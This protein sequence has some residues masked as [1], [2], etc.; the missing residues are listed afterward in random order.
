[1]RAIL[2]MPPESPS[3]SVL[4]PETPEELRRCL[5]DGLGR[6]CPVPPHQ[7]FEQVAAKQLGLEPLGQRQ[8]IVVAVC[9]HLVLDDDDQLAVELRLD[10]HFDLAV[11]EQDEHVEATMAKAFEEAQVDDLESARDHYS[12]AEGL[13]EHEQSPRHALVLVSLSELELQRGRQREATALIDRALAI[14][15]TH[16]AALRARAQLAEQAGE[17]AISAAMHHRLLA[18]LDSAT[19][20]SRT[21]DKIA[22]ESLVAAR[23]AISSALE[24]QPNDRGLLER[25]QAVYEAQG[26]WGEAVGVGVKIAE[27]LTDPQE[28]ARAFVAAA[29]IASG[30][31]NNPRLAVALYEAAIEDDARVAGAFEAVEA[32]LVRTGDF[33]GVAKAYKRQLERLEGPSEAGARADLLRKLARVRRE[34]LQDP[35]AAIEALDRLALEQPADVEARVELAELLRQTNQPAL[36]TRVLEAAA[37]IEPARSQTYR[38]LL[39]LFDNLD[40]VDRAYN[41]SAVLVALGEADINEQLRYAQY[42]PERL[43]PIGHVLD[44]DIWD[45]LLPPDHPDAVHDLLVAIEPAALE[46]WFA[47]HEAQVRAAAPPEK[48]RQDP[49]KTTVGAVKTFHWASRVMC[50]PEP[51]IYAMPDQSRLTVATLPVKSSAVVLGRQALSGRSLAELSFMAAH[52]LAFFRPGSRLLPY[53]SDVGQV[54]SLVQAAASLCRPEMVS[55][56]DETAS[57]LRPRL[58]A[59]LA[60]EAREAVRAAVERLLDDGGKLDV[61]QWVR[62]VEIVA[63]RAALLVAG[64]VTVAGNVLAVAG[65]AP[66]GRSARDRARELLPYSISQSYT[67]LRHLLGVAV[68]QR[69]ASERPSGI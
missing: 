67:A 23:Q 27:G 60:P 69:R 4:V 41:A 64:D 52:H 18:H 58:E 28:R 49:A 21:L 47:I 68:G 43:L 31:A 61:V 7:P 56:L 55:G 45:Q 3:P 36:A 29:Q 39:E 53:F 44:D 12:Q 38:S 46:A 30:K 20:R 33:E 9:S 22:S 14:M 32:E 34:R 66:G 26:A 6:L 50:V 51:A 40:D 1:M 54:R 15:P 63:C 10:D 2:F 8:T 65:S 19:E 62:S 35:H 17:S 57:T 16:I 59:W 13:L 25:L 42:A 5:D 37:R 11:Q 24:I 48:L